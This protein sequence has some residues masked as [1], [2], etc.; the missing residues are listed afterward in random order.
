MSICIA[1]L[2]DQPPLMRCLVTNGSRLTTQAT[3]HSL[4]TQAWAVT[5]LLAT[6]RQSAVRLHLR[7]PS[8][9]GLLYSFSFTLARIIFTATDDN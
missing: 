4:H 9:N 7:N 1:H 5:R 2:V 8:I 3:A 6:Q